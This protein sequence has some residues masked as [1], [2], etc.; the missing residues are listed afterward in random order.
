[1]ENT[2]EQTEAAAPVKSGRQL[3]FWVAVV[4]F[5]AGIMLTRYVINEQ[6]VVLLPGSGGDF[7]LQSAEGPV[8]LQDYRGQVVAL[9]FGYMT[10]PDICPTSM[11]KMAEAIKALPAEQAGQVQ[12]IMVSVDPDRDTPEALAIYMNAFNPD[13][14]GLTDIKENIDKVTSQYGALYY[15]VP[16]KDS[17]MGYV[18]DHS[19]VVYLIDQQGKLAAQLRHESSIEEMTQAMQSI[20]QG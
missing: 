7:T 11:W 6:G 1:M 5:F 3:L 14:I 8:S 10:C 4:C 16:L 19:S 12:G 20:L 17:A 15:K 2:V 13:F 9:Y 18:V